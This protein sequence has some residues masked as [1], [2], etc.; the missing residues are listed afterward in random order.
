MA[1]AIGAR[2]SEG[3]WRLLLPLP[4][5]PSTLRD[6]LR[7]FCRGTQLDRRLCAGA[8][9]ISMA[10]PLGV[11]KFIGDM[12]YAVAHDDDDDD[13]GGHGDEHGDEHDDGFADG[14]PGGREGAGAQYDSARVADL[15]RLAFNAT[16]RSRG[17]A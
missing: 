14:E 13:G 3:R 9:R 4:G 2:C 11:R 10:D 5:T 7:R 8:E 1:A 12:S 17:G 16:P 15:R 6:T